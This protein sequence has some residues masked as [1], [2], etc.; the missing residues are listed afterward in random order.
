M[1]STE[2]AFK[3]TE[4][5]TNYHGTPYDYIEWGRWLASVY[6]SG[7][8]QLI[9]QY[10]DGYTPLDRDEIPGLIALLIM[11]YTKEYK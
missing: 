9:H 11:I 6:P 1:T 10:S 5:L 2:P 7:G 3:V 8:C 4:G